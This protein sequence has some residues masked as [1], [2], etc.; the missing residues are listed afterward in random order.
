VVATT[1]GSALVMPAE[2][3][4]ILPAYLTSKSVEYRTPRPIFDGQ[5]RRWGPA[6]LDAAATDDNH[7]CDFYFDEQVDGLPRSWQATTPEQ[8]ECG[9]CVWCNPPY[10]KGEEVCIQ[11]HT[12]CKKERCKDRGHH[13]LRRIASLGEWVAKGRDEA[14]RWGGPVIMLIPERPDTDW[15]R[16]GIRQQPPEAGAYIGTMGH[17]NGGPAARYFPAENPAAEWRVYLWENLAVDVVSIEGRLDFGAPGV[18]NS[19][20]FPS[21]VVTFYRPSGLGVA[22][23]AGLLAAA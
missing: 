1:D 9:R 21:V 5:I 4:L 23:T 22:A 7:L 20:T 19:A 6:W 15:W 11:P 18:E 3:K 10:T 17:P 13:L 16:E 8:L 2:K 12:R 14:L